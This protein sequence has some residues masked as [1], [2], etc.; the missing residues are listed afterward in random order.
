VGG[1]EVDKMTLEAN[2][3]SIL[4]IVVILCEISLSSLEVFEACNCEGLSLS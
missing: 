3:L 2:I 4:R 1:G